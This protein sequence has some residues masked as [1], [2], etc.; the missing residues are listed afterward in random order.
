MET[1]QFASFRSRI[2]EDYVRRASFSEFVA[3]AIGLFCILLFFRQK[4]PRIPGAKVHGYPCWY[5][6]AI[7]LQTRFVTQ[8]YSMIDSGYAKVC[9]PRLH[10]IFLL[11]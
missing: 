10:F 3:I 1:Q 5:E 4:H 6:P 7:L 9:L 2:V 8:A 11:T